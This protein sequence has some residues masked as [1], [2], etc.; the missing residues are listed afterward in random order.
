MEIAVAEAIASGTRD[1]AQQDAQNDLRE[2][3]K[4]A[5]EAGRERSRKLI[6]VTNINRATSAARYNPAGRLLRD[7]YVHVY[8]NSLRANLGEPAVVI[9]A[10][11]IEDLAGLVHRVRPGSAPLQAL[12]AVG[13][14]R[15]LAV[16]DANHAA[17]SIVERLRSIGAERAVRHAPDE[18]F[19]GDAVRVH[20]SRHWYLRCFTAH[21]E[22]ATKSQQP[23]TGVSYVEQDLVAET[24]ST[25]EV[26]P[27]IGRDGIPLVTVHNT[28]MNSVDRALAAGETDIVPPT[29]VSETQ[30]DTFDTLRR[31]VRS[32]WSGLTVDRRAQWLRLAEAAPMGNGERWADLDGGQQSK[33]IRN[34]L[35]THRRDLL[36]L[37]PDRAVIGADPIGAA[38]RMFNHRE[39]LT[40]AIQDAKD[41]STQQRPAPFPEHSAP[42]RGPNRS[43]GVG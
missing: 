21:V 43:R 18:R 40:A 25:R 2:L 3:R 32:T 23:L 20:V 5:V 12:Q 30:R 10:Q 34:Y 11:Q 33:I 26:R 8:L 4:Q 41:L 24:L 16:D 36:D 35:H 42:E 17:T 28:R 31:Q 37:S 39:A 22:V 7:W 14:V 13:V 15:N 38:R 29:V 1:Q 27:I 19:D 6:K 9:D